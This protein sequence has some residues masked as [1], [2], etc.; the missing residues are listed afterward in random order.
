MDS[1]DVA[2][3]GGRVAGTATAIHLG[4]AG[5]RVALFEGA[6][7]PSLPPLSCP[8]IFPG[9]MAM[10]DELGVAEKDY[11]RNTP[12]IPRFVLQ[13][14]DAYQVELVFPSCHGRSHVYALDRARFDFALWQC[15][16]ST[17]GVQARPGERVTRLLRAGARVSGVDTVDAAGR[18]RQVTARAVVGADG[19]SSRVAREVGAEARLDQGHPPVTLA[20]AYWSGVGPFDGR[21]PLVQF[22]LRRGGPLFMVMDSADGRTGVLAY[23]PDLLFVGGPAAEAYRRLI[24]ETPAVARRLAH[25][26]LETEVR[27]VRGLRWAAR[28]ACGPGWALAGDAWQRS[29]PYASQGIYDALLS[30]RLLAR[31]LAR[32]LAGEASWDDALGE[33]ARALEAEAAPVRRAAVARVRHEIFTDWP[34]WLVGTAFRWLHQDQDFQLRFARL[35]QRAVDPDRWLTVPAVAGALARGFAADLRSFFRGTPTRASIR[36]QSTEAEP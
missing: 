21:G 1:V 15:A 26:R 10:L 7:L 6:R 18:R 30:A 27:A 11:A 25:A 19:F 4:R 29:D 33:Y 31:S 35:Y 5:F 9:A 32:H 14:R 17:P 20:Y 8:A 16:A 12:R 2:I 13:V 22:H 36:P 28:P 3:V 23:G 34:D 24:A